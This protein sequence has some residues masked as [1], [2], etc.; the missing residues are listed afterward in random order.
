MYVLNVL[1]DAKGQGEDRELEA[2]VA[3]EEKRKRMLLTRPR[4]PAMDINPGRCQRAS[5]GNLL[6]S[7]GLLHCRKVRQL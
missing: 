1:L 3:R 5:S 6:L 4:C 2:G 7:H